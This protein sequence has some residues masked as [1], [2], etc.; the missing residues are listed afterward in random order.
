MISNKPVQI[1]LFSCICGLLIKLYF[2]QYL[3]FFNDLDLFKYWSYY[4]ADKGFKPFYANV[5]S[6]YLPGYHY[7]LW[8]LGEMRVFLINNSI[9]FNE[10]IFYKTPS[11]FADIISVIFVYKIV[12]RFTTEKNALVT[13][14]IYLVNPAFMAN[15]T[16]WGQADSFSTLFIIISLYMLISNRLIISAL[17]IALATII[18]PIGILD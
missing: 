18:K 1:L 11:I 2:A 5:W 7:I 6:D 12:K 4:L 8:I 10:I 16:F 14:L 13:S 9:P 17:M 15:S 3:T